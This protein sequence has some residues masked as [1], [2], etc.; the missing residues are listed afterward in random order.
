[1]FDSQS[2]EISIVAPMYNCE[3]YVDGMLGRLSQQSFKDF[4]VICVDD[5]STDGTLNHIKSFCEGDSRF[6]YITQENQGAGAARNAGMDIAKGKYLMFLDADDEH[7]PD[8]LKELYEAAERHNAGEVHC[9][10][11]QYDYKLSIQSNNLGFSL[12]KFPHDTP[13]K[14][15]TITNLFTSTTFAAWNALFRKSLIDQYE[16]RFSTTTISN[17]TFF[18]NAYAAIADTIVGIHKELLRIRRHHNSGSLTT[19]RWKLTE[20]LP[21]VLQE[22]YDWLKKHNLYEKHSASYLTL[23]NSSIYY[24]AS[25]PMNYKFVK[26]YATLICKNEDIQ[27]MTDEEFFKKYWFRFS[28][29]RLAKRLRNYIDEPE[30]NYADAQKVANQMAAVQEINRI[31]RE[32]YG[33][34]LDPTSVE[35]YIYRLESRKE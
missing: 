1:M 3:E 12:E 32:K 10:Y 33:R 22:L 8:L 5:G 16:L 18:I 26:A 19:K 28:Q 9:L 31:A 4:E 7:H 11:E 29:D 6:K 17:D 14:V 25:F 35:A 24:N 27:K 20:N 21:Q 23:V 15:D 2:I 13:V 34:I 30:N